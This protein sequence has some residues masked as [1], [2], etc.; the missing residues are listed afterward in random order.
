LFSSINAVTRRTKSGASGATTGGRFR[1]AVSLPGTF[2]GNSASSDA[3][4][5]AWFRRTTS[6]PFFL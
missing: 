3:S 4:T 1:V 5:A 6:A 2:T